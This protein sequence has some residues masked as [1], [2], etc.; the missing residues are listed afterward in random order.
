MPGEFEREGKITPNP[1][2]PGE[3]PI[4]EPEKGPPVEAPPQKK[5]P[6]EEPKP[7]EPERRA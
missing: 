1:P 2:A 5:S 4:E 3:L 7:H 6:M